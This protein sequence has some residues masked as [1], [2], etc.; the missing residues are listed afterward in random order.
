MNTKE[1]YDEIAA[2]LRA[3][4]K[5]FELSDQQAAQGLEDGSIALEMSVDGDRRRFVRAVHQ[6]RGVRIY[7][8]RIV[9]DDP[10]DQPGGCSCGHT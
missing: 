8:G 3:V 9:H 1:M 5:A 2:L 4:G 10:P 7:D 6:G